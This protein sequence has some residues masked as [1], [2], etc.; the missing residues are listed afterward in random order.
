MTTISV[1]LEWE[2]F[3]LNHSSG[4]LAAWLADKLVSHFT[5]ILTCKELNVSANS[6]EYH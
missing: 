3:Q 1:L 6:I 2:A 4:S 5:C